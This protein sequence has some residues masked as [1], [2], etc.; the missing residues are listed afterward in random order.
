MQNEAK[1]RAVPN[2]ARLLH[3]A[4]EGRLFCVRLRYTSR[5]KSALSRREWPET[6]RFAA[7]IIRTVKE[8]CFKL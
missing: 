3:L 8:F 6:A 2:E 4:A 7:E 1:S 5:A